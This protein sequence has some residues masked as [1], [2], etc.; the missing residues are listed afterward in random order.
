ME[1]SGAGSDRAAYIAELQ[2]WREDSN[3]RRC[4]EA[5]A[6]AASA[7]Y[8]HR[9]IPRLRAPVPASRSTTSHEAA[10][11][12]HAGLYHAFSTTG[13]VEMLAADKGDNDMS[14]I[15]TADISAQGSGSGDDVPGPELIAT[16]HEVAGATVDQR[17][18]EEISGGKIVSGRNVLPDNVL[19]SLMTGPGGA[20]FSLVCLSQ[21]L[22]QI[23]SA[24]RRKVP[25]SL[26]RLSLSHTEY[27]CSI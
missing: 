3:R 27:R 13:T 9:Y 22:S 7:P 17:S 6:A 21:V 12:S 15:V 25:P 16:T 8:G 11:K 4:A 1:P 18:I 5:N 23:A 14:L 24:I 19:R 10:S 2:Q 26:P 20:L